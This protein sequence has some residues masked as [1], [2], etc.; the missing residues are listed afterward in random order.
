MGSSQAYF[1]GP[2]RGR[3]V[4]N[5]QSRTLTALNR[6]AYFSTQDVYT[7]ARREPLPDRES[8][9]LIKSQLATE[10][11]QSGRRPGERQAEART[12]PA[13]KR[14][15]NRPGRRREAATSHRLGARR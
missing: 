1:R 12:L 6:A 4:G 13:L 9:R 7:D 15:G 11:N 8:G 3:I 14:L 2:I 5:R 10:G